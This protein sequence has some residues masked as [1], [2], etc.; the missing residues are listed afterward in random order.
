MQRSACL[1][2]TVPLRALPETVVRKLTVQ[3]RAHG[4]GRLHPSDASSVIVVFC[5]LQTI[6]STSH[7]LEPKQDCCSSNIHGSRVIMQTKRLQVQ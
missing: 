4:P 3:G 7:L 1:I 6:I 2:D 5:S